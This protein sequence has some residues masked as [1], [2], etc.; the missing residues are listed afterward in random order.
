MEPREPIEP[1]VRRTPDARTD[2]TLSA[3]ADSAPPT[4][5]RGDSVAPAGPAP[6]PPGGRPFGR[7]RLERELGRGGMGIVWKAWDPELS[8]HVALKQILSQGNVDSETVGRFVREARVAAK[9]RHPHILSVHDVGVQDGQHYFTTDYIDG[10]SLDQV[11]PAQI[12]PRRAVEWAR[13]IAEALAYAHE[14]GV[15]HRDVKPSN[16]LLDAELKPYVMDFGL[17][18]EVGA[19]RSGAAPLTLSGAILGTPRYMSP[20]QADGVTERIGPASDQFSLGVVLHEMLTGRALFDGEGVMEILRSVTAQEVSPPSRQ[21]RGV[22]RD[23][24]TICLK[25]LEKDPGRRYPSMR[26]AAVDLGRFL[27]GAPIEARAPG[28][29]ELLVRFAARRRVAVAIAVIALVASAAAW[30]WSESSRRAQQASTARA[31]S[32]EEALRKSKLVADAMVRW[33]VLAPR[34]AELDSIAHDDRRPD[35]ARRTAAQPILA[36]F[37]RYLDET[38]DDP[39]SRAVATAYV[40]WARLLAGDRKGGLTALRDAARLD[41]D[42]PHAYALEAAAI[43][44]DFQSALPPL[45]LRHRSQGLAFDPPRA[46]PPEITARA[47]EIEAILERSKDARVWGKSVAEE[48]EG[49]IS[50]FLAGLRGDYPFAEE[51]L[52]RAIGSP[53]LGPIRSELRLARGLVRYQQVRLE[54]ALADFEAVRE[55]WPNERR[56]QVI[57]GLV[58]AAMAEILAESGVDPGPRSREA[59]ELYR[60]ALELRPDLH[61]TRGHRARA[62]SAIARWQGERGED[63]RP[64]YELAEEDLDEVIRLNIDRFSNLATRADLLTQRGAW[65]NDRGGNGRPWLDRAI[66]DYD[67]M[68]HLD[69]DDADGWRGRATARAALAHCPQTGVSEAAAAVDGALADLEAAQARTSDPAMVLAERGR[70]WSERGDIEARAAGDPRASCAKA[71]EL[72]DQA[73]EAAPSF[74]VAWIERGLARVHLAQWEAQR[75]I[76]PSGS[77][78]RALP[79]LEEALRLDPTASDARAG[80]G[81]LWL[82]RGERELA[83]RIDARASLDKAIESHEENARRY[84]LNPRFLSNLAGVR[85]VRGGA[86]AAAGGNPLPWYEKATASFDDLLKAWP[87]MRE[88][89]FNRATTM[90][91]IGDWRHQRG[92]DA[93]ESYQRAIADYDELLRAAQEDIETRFGRANAN[94]GLARHMASRGKDEK[95]V[96]RSAIEDLSAVIDK[97]PAHG[98]AWGMRAWMKEILGQQEQALVDYTRAVELMPG[99]A[100]FRAGLDRVK[101]RLGR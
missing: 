73:I 4:L 54:D 90:E 86:E 26:E 31:L 89:R 3:Q 42:V 9:L 66:A 59:L 96:V 71:V 50:G 11:T 67:R 28:T 32:A 88:A 62:L 101:K 15:V 18:K 69:P 82:R 36:E 94:V 43:L 48:C 65:E 46:L 14:N 16:V 100:M 7:Y 91:R 29:I 83:S 44:C 84:P 80:L 72:L 39:T 38:P 41:R 35:A 74:A 64:S 37:E 23:I 61:D 53:D 30:I 92:L 2:A 60:R 97:D 6:L 19:A 10:M 75:G 40:G 49:A 70:T 76:D 5:I 77:L 63:A 78:D 22:H 68:I 17:A 95:D 93:T 13:A 81:N 12:P 27:D 34:L 33:T 52:S 20:E 25:L 1:T 51:R 56:I 98:A 45:R 57:D 79:D 47:A 87:G 55:R 99:D 21:A 85:M 24:D 58:R 8:R